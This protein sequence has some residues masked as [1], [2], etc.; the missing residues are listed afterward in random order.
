V[1]IIAYEE[2]K[3]WWRHGYAIHLPRLVGL[4]KLPKLPAPP[5]KVKRLA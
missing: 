5:E 1:T 3:L 4:F 2:T